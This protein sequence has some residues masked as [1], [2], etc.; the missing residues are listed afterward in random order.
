[1]TKCQRGYKSN[2][3]IIIIAILLWVDVCGFCGVE[4]LLFGLKF[5][6][7]LINI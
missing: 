2:G 4:R 6:K 1:M 5:F 7:Y 3:T